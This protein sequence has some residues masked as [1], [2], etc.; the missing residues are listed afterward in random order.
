[1]HTKSS[2]AMTCAKKCEENFSRTAGRLKHASTPHASTNGQTLCNYLHSNDLRGASR[3]ANISTAVTY[4][5]RQDMQTNN[6]EA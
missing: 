2:T 6:E 3:R 1:M 4:V 5:M